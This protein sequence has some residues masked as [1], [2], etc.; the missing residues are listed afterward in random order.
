MRYFIDIDILQNSL[1]DI[2]IFKNVLIDINI[3]IDIFQS[4]LNN[5][6]I[7]HIPISIF[8]SISS[9]LS[10][11]CF[12]DIDILK[13]CRYFI[14]ILENGNIWTINIDFSLRKHEKTLEFDKS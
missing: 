7:L 2:D 13:K 1:I 4:V 3:Y 14:H 8:L 12:V 6:D 10:Y 5:I 11:R 9:K